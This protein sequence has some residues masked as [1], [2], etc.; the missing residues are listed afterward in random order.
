MAVIGEW[1]RRIDYLLRRRRFDDDLRR[2]MEAHRELLDDPAAFGNTLRLRD[3]ARDAW[4]W[5]WLDDLVH[6]ARLGVRML[7]RSPGFTGAAVLTL[8]LGIGVN[9]GM[10]RLVDALLLRPLHDGPDRVMALRSRAASSPAGY[11]RISYPNYRD[12]RDGTSDILESL[13]A[14]RLMFVGLDHGGRSRRTLA[15]AVTAD[16]F[17]TFDVPLARGRA[18]TA[19]EEQPGSG[20]R[21]AVISHRLWEQRGAS[22]SGSDDVVLLNG[23]PFTIVGVAA[24]GFTGGSIPGPEVWLPLG[25]DR[26]FSAPSAGSLHTSRDAHELDVLGRLRE[27]ITLE[28]ASA[29]LATVSL[30][31][32]QAYPD[33]NAGHRFELSPPARLM[34]MPGPGGGGMM[35]MIAAALMVMPAIVLLVGCLNLANLLLARGQGRRQEMAIRSSLGA[36]RGRLTRQLICEGLILAVL[37]GAAGLLLSSWATRALLSSVGAM[38]PVDLTLPALDLDWRVAVATLAFSLAATAVFSAGPAWLLAG[39]AFAAD[40]K[41][42][43]GDAKWRLAGLRIS[44]VLVVGQVALSL[45]LLAT[46]GLFMTSALAAASADPGFRLDGGVVVE[47]DPGLA[48]YDDARSHA[49]HRALVERLRSVPGVES[50]T[51]G[52]DLQF[53]SQSE[54]REIVPG[55]AAAAGSR[56]IGAVFTAVGRDYARTL[57]LPMLGGRDFTEAELAPGSPDAVAI[58]DDELAQR[59][60]PGPSSMEEALGRSI[61]FADAQGPEAGR[62]MR[63]VGVVPAIKHSLGNPRPFPHVYV[64]LGQHDEKAMTLQ[65]RLADPDAE[66]SMVSTLA[67]VVRDLDPRLPVLR[68]E[69]FRE[70]LDRGLDIWIYRTGAAV[71]VAFAAIALLLALVGVYGI[72]SY[73]VSRRT[74]EFG[75]RIATGADPRALLWLVLREG[76]SVTAVGVVIGTLLAIGAGQVLRGILYEAEAVEPLVLVAAPLILVAASLAASFFP[77]R[78]ATRVDPIVALRS[79]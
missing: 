28:A 11:R 17:R 2:E 24:R 13:A 32:E 75:I 50:V 9:V 26:A 30:R 19:V 53:S 37:G 7:R 4:G 45:V 63:I 55:G 59:L 67:R 12:L 62:T 77:A 41:Q 70:H 16:Y 58:V 66:R 46:G 51:I 29:A 64:P 25:A 73:V 21:V 57:G 43:L 61:A 72:K 47:I 40:L 69:T 33:V 15:A 6:D 22:S 76:G 54:S 27:G 79:E 18:F 39:R 10:F 65:L 42:Q 74:R 68:I 48:G 23:N 71:F 78:R 3:E 36:G 8:A 34:F 20:V 1:V 5:R 44:N 31:L 56:P 14:V 49:S 60:W 52:S 38:L 35:T